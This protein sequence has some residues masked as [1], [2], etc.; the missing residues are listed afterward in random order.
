MLNADCQVRG[1]VAEAGDASALAA[2]H[3]ENP[4][5]ERSVRRGLR[6]RSGEGALVAGTIAAVVLA[7]VA[8]TAGGVHALDVSRTVQHVQAAY[9]AMMSAVVLALLVLAS[10]L[11]LRLLR[12]VKDSETCFLEFAENMEGVMWVLDAPTRAFCYLS[13]RHAHVWGR[14][15]D[16]DGETPEAWLERVHVEDRDIARRVLLE[17]EGERAQAEVRVIHPCGSVR[18]VR[19]VTFPICDERGHVCRVAGIAEDVTEHVLYEKERQSRERTEESLRVRNAFL[20]NLSHEVRTP[21]TTV[22][23]FAE[24]VRDE[25]ITMEQREHAEIVKR[26]AEALERTLGAALDIAQLECA[27]LLAWPEEVDMVDEAL[28]AAERLRP[29]AEAKRLEILVSGEQ[30]SLT[31]RTDRRCLRRILDLL[32]GIGTSNTPAGKIYVWVETDR[33]EVVVKVR[34]MSDNAIPKRLERAE[35]GETLSHSHVQLDMDLDV[36]LQLVR[37]LTEVIEGTLDVE[38][39]PGTGQIFTLRIPRELESRYEASVSLPALRTGTDIEA[40]EHRWA[41]SG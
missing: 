16:T 23:G 35:G 31:G 38:A 41:T 24:V 39:V 26:N 17:I 37:K 15:S 34:D 12:R 27:A 11:A 33:G 4:H 5:G 13:P 9:V 8:T 10:L 36:S 6:T 32:L 20:Q 30:D 28:K 14:E 25:A 22:V 40:T 1:D 29:M 2:P 3:G 7:L 18:W 19:V 21:L